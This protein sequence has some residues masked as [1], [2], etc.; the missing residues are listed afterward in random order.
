MALFRAGAQIILGRG[1]RA[2]FWHDCWL[3]GGLSVP[4]AAPALASFARLS[5]ITVGQAL[6][7]NRW[8]RDI[9]GGLS[10][11]ALAQYLRLWDM[12]AATSLAPGQQ[13]AVIW[14]L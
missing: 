13:D 5:S 9:R 12:V 4:E 2:L 8:V 10:V 6:A 7:N 1:D 11:P 3:P 14:C